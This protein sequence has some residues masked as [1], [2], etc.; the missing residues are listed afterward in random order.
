MPYAEI[1]P[2]SKIIVLD[3]LTQY[4]CLY[5]VMSEVGFVGTYIRKL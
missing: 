3:N 5:K 2:P 1:R 4:W